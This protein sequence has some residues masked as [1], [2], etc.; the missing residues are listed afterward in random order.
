MFCYLT[1]GPRRKF[2]R[3]EMLVTRPDTDLPPRGIFGYQ[4]VH[5]LMY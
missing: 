2:V 3:E 1:N 4:L 5:R